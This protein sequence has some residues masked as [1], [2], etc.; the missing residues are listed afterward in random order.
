[1]TKYTR[2]AIFIIF[3]SILS[4]VL[5]NWMLSKLITAETD[6]AWMNVWFCLIAV[7]N[8]VIVVATCENLKDNAELFEIDQQIKKL[9]RRMK[10][11]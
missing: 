7:S 5:V 1:M 10:N 2:K 9:E 11:V 8:F 4:F 3:C 6:A